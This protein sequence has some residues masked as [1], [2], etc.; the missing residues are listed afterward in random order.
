MV[1]YLKKILRSEEVRKKHLNRDMEHIEAFCWVIVG[2][3]LM[4]IILT[5]LHKI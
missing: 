2:G 5:L 4:I 3:G 1:N